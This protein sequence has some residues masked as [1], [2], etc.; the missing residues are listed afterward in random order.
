MPFCDYQI[1]IFIRHTFPHFKYYI[2]H[3]IFENWNRTDL[4]C[5]VCYAALNRPKKYKVEYHPR[6]TTTSNE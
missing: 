3:F 6:K 4:I 5:I 1:Y 2:L